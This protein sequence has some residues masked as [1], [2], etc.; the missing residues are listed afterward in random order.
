MFL[1]SVAAFLLLRE[2]LAGWGVG[3]M[4]VAEW[5][6]LLGLPAALLASGGRSVAGAVGWRPLS[7]RTAGGAM[8][9]GAAGLPVA[10]G[11]F[12][13]QSVFLP[14]DTSV[15]EGLNRELVPGGPGEFLFLA[16]AVAVTPALCEEFLFRGVLLNG[17]RPRLG[18]VPAVTG[19]ALLFGLLHWAPGGGFRI[20]PSVALG[21]I[22]GW[23][24]WRGRS[25]G[26]A[27]LVH[28]THNLLILTV[29]AAA[30][31]G[32]NPPAPDAP[33]GAPPLLVLAGGVA[34]LLV[35]GQLLAPVPLPSHPETDR[36][37]PP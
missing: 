35:G 5:V 9:L 18:A 4:A 19:T 20:L 3:G 15:V 8:T 7:L 10:W 13:I 22:L 29:A 24:A 6:A 11:V 23:A 32:P 16:L 37:A 28:L 31:W 26:A 36:P 17:V 14:V 21:V 2:G 1:V 30:A 33:P 27:V 34:L 25:L 12:W